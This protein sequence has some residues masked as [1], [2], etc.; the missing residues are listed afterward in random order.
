M[1]T[2]GIVILAS[3]FVVIGALVLWFGLR[4]PLSFAEFRR[5]FRREFFSLSPHSSPAD[6]DSAAGV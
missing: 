5:R 4:K 2:I 1:E 3:H 6:S